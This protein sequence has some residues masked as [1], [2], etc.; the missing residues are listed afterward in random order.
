MRSRNS[1]NL[2]TLLIV[3]VGILNAQEYQADS[4]QTDSLVEL[5]RVVVTATRSARKSSELPVAVSIITRHQI[6][7]SA[8]RNVDDL[9][10]IVSGVQVRRSVGMGEGVPGDIMMRGIPGALASSRVLVLVDGI[11]TNAAGTPFLIL[12]ELPL[13][14]VERVE[15]LNG[16]YSALYG[17][18]AFGGVINIITRTPEKTALETSLQTSQPFNAVH[19][20]FGGTRAFDALKEGGEQA[21]FGGNITGAWSDGKYSLLASGGARRVGS[22]LFRDSAFVR[23]GKITYSKSS[24]NHDYRDLRLFVKSSTKINEHVDLILH[25]RS[26]SSEL[27]FGLT[28]NVNPPKDVVTEGGKF[29]FG[30]YLNAKFNTDVS[31]R[32]G[33]YFRT[34][35]GS[36][37]N[38]SPTEEGY[39]PSI[40]SSDSKDWSSEA[41]LTYNAHVLGVFTLGVDHLR[42]RINF[43][44]TINTITDDTLSGSQEISDVISYTGCYVQNELK[45]PLRVGVVS[46]IRVDL[47]ST[48][49]KAVSPRL[50]VTWRGIDRLTLRFS[51]GQAFR[52]PAASE[53]FMP[54]FAV[55]S[56][57]ALRSNSKLK[58]ERISSVEGGA[59]Y[60]LGTYALLK[61]TLYSNYLKDLVIPQ[62]LTLTADGALITHKNVN[63]ASSLGVENVLELK[64]LKYLTGELSYTWQTSEVSNSGVA[65]DYVPQHTFA[66]KL[67]G[68]KSWGAITCDGS[69]S[70]LY[71]G[72][73]VFRDL[74]NSYLSVM[75]DTVLMK[76]PV[77]ALDPYHR[78]DLTLKASYH[79][80]YW[81]TFMV[82][83]MLEAIIEESPGTLAPG[84][85]ASLEFGARVF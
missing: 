55:N 58:A 26:F 21:Y 46:G 2:L 5:E 68:G 9:L 27:G 63:S 14:A 24:Q 32:L 65:L 50:G 75:P 13:E 39:V 57:I 48:D 74:N 4:L 77:V 6:E 20:Y 43:G 78:I 31:M 33:G 17:A 52:A 49:Q 84:R 12:N 82:Q 3:L 25:M 67:L 62:I 28:R 37:R 83:N 76:T 73:R 81:I 36:F 15:V 38:Q 66:L 7:T 18:N 44:P 11:P 72:G 56:S 16:P 60:K 23:A 47:P 40:W 29:L 42:N 64:A 1:R 45:L 70:F 85:F 34:V 30:P 8:A 59:E 53:L 61:S 35:S 19:S 22:Y 80:R 69:A 71:T 10:S 41:V 54:D 51:A 79:D